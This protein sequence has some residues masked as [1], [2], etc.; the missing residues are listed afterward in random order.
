MQIRE[1]FGRFKKLQNIYGDKTLDP[2]YGCG[3]I[4][5][6]DLC[7]VFM[8]PTGRNISSNK[9]W[10]G[11]KAPWLGTKNVWNM[12]CC[13][14]LFDKKFADA[15]NSKKSKDWDYNFSEDVYKEVCK[16]SL[17]ITNLSKAIQIDSRALPDQIFK[18][19]LDL[20]KK[21]M[22][23][24]KPKAIISFGNQVGSILLN[25]N[26]KVSEWRKKSENIKIGETSI[27]IFTVYY[28]VGQGMRNMKIAKED[29]SWIL[30]SFG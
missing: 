25:K 3:E 20:F 18:E 23:I 26:I 11:I 15:I 24:I 22:Q 17:Y 2:I 19:Y 14:G 1:L 5:H 12:L 21:E 28:P 8:N 30:N 6:P 9:N 4:N 10:K 27:K 7:L 13:L 29:I 16:N